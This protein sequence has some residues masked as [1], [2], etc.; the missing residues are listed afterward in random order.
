[1]KNGVNPKTP[2]SLARH[3]TIEL[4]LNVYTSLTV[5]DQAAALAS[6][7][8]P[9]VFLAEAVLKATGTNGPRMVRIGP[10]GSRIRLHS[11]WPPAATA[12]KFTIVKQAW[13]KG[14]FSQLD[15]AVCIEL[16]SGE[17]EI[18]TRGTREGTP[19]FKT[20]AFG[21]SAT[22]PEGSQYRRLWERLKSLMRE[23]VDRFAQSASGAFASDGDR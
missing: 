23:L 17:G 16:R 22:S 14:P 7:P 5:H 15:A 12:E 10:A 4:T 11:E 9:P 6:L 21:R 18:R 3:S 8:A 2:Q 13:K 20:G 1:M 19:V